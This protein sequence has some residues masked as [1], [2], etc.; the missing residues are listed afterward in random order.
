MKKSTLQAANC[1]V[2]LSTYFGNIEVHGLSETI[3][4]G[5]GGPGGFGGPGDH[6]GLAEML[7]YHSDGGVA[8]LTFHEVDMAVGRGE[9]CAKEALIRLR[10]HA[11]NLPHPLQAEFLSY[12][13]KERTKNNGLSFSSL[14]DNV[15]ESHPITVLKRYDGTWDIT[16]RYDLDIVNQV[17]WGDDCDGVPIM[18]KDERI[19]CLVQGG[20]GHFELT[21][22]NLLG[23]LQLEE[24]YDE[25]DVNR[26]LRKVC[27][28]EVFMYADEFHFGTR[29]GADSI[30]WE[31]ARALL[32]M[33]SRS[34]NASS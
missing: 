19:L 17:D 29:E 26:E 2:E 6:E 32:P 13:P 22:E 31:V 10:A 12:L 20:L 28:E 15:M 25:A 8:E 11:L 34:D 1:S 3:E 14:Y 33:V 21:F 4:Y 24:G 16:F 30:L 9:L 18:L 27:F 23:W 7:L 5:N